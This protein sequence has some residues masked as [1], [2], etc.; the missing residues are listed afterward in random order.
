[1]SDY[2]SLLHIPQVGLCFQSISYEWV[3]PVSS[4]RI[5]FFKENVLLFYMETFSDISTTA[6]DEYL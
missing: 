3:N 6:S 2:E 4:I 5:L 1:M